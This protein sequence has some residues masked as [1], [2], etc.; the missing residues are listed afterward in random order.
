MK[1]W[2]IFLIRDNAL[3]RDTE[4]DKHGETEIQRY[5]YLEIYRYISLERQ[6]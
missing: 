1:R 5:T 6:R 2:V 4:I 3:A